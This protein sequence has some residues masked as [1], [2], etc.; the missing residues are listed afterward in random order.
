MQ[1]ILKSNTISTGLAMFA[2]FF[3]AG[4]I[5]FPL[6]VGQ[7]AQDK[8]MY[9]MMGLFISAVLV[10]FIGLI[11]MTLFDG[12]YKNFF[13]RIG[14]VP[15]FIVILAIMGLIG[16]LGA[17]PR[18]ITVSHSTVK[19]FG[20]NIS[21]P[22]FS[23]IFCFFIYLATVKRSKIM[24]ILGFILSPLKLFFLSIIII[25]GI[26]NA[27]PALPSPYSANDVFWHALS[28]GYKTMDLLASF[29]FSSIAI[30]CLKKEYAEDEGKVDVKRLIKMTIKASC[31]GAFLLGIVY[32]G[33]S[34]VASV[35]STLLANVKPDELIGVISL[36]VLG[37]YAGI[38]ASIC[39]AL[40]CFGTG[41]ALAAVF[42]EFVHEDLTMKKLQYKPALIITLILAF[43]ISTL[44]FTGIMSFLA[45][46]LFICYPALIALSIL[47]ILYKLYNFKPV[48]LPVLIVFLVSLILNL[49]PSTVP[50][51]A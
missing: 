51:A 48:K 21:L 7:F 42:A 13:D 28:E 18:V 44:E 34:Y 11:A 5:V 9:A 2:M 49:W 30:L 46:I 22:I 17:L 3:G 26:W 23:A 35:N 6:A 33:F 19:M 39:V 12:N 31:I 37:P 32:L 50:V 1:K 47:N 8:N 4:N 16:P 36:H 20:M 25:L 29:F 15:G 45:P 27:S 38:V 24:D 10:P 41:I 40:A 14:K 43:F